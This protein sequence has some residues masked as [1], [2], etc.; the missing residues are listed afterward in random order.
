MQ[1]YTFLKNLREDNGFTNIFIS[2]AP[3]RSQVRAGVRRRPVGS[4]PRG[5]GGGG[6][7]GGGEGVRRAPLGG[8]QRGGEGVR[9]EPQGQGEDD[10]KQEVQRRSRYSTHKGKY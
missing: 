4:A 3:G 5:G 2:S 9:R 10:G 6:R 8:R 1:C 7:G